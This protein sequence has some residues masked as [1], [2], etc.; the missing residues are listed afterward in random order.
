MKENDN[1]SDIFE[2]ALGEIIRAKLKEMDEKVKAIDKTWDQA[3]IVEVLT[4]ANAYLQIICG[5]DEGLYEDW[6]YRLFVTGKD[7]LVIVQGTEV[8]TEIVKRY[9]DARD[10]DKPSN[11][12]NRK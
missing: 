11:K 9:G 4:E 10:E 8:H 12:K 2:E 5:D 7:K 6:R 3:D 1:E